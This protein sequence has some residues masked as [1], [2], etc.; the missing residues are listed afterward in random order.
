VARTYR[1]LLVWQ[2]TR[3]LAVLTYRHTGNFPKTEIF[4]LQSQIRR[5]AVSVVSNIAEGQ[6][7]LTTGEFAHFLGNSRGSLVELDTQISI[8]NELGYLDKE[9]FAVLEQKAYEVL[10]L[11]NLLIAKLKKKT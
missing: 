11:L 5:A 3:H 9:G 7:R 10:G 4:G 1:D 2:K 6:G 8:A